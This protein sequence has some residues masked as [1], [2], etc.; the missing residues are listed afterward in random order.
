MWAPLASQ[1][2]S[3]DGIDAPASSGGAGTAAGAAGGTAAPGREAVSVFELAGKDQRGLLAEVLQLLASNGC[4]VG[5]GH[6]RG[7]RADGLGGW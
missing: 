7:R 3:V 5:L 4:E 1:V 6:L 2:L